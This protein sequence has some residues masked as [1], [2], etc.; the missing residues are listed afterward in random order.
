MNGSGDASMDRRGFLKGATFAGIGVA[1]AGAGLVGCAPNGESDKVA[2]DGSAT[3]SSIRA[4]NPDSI[5]SAPEIDESD[6]IETITCDVAVVGAGIS[7]VA[8]AR[9]AAEAGARVIV[10]EKN[11]DIE[12]HGFGCGVINSTFARSLGAEVDPLDVM[13]EYERRSYTRVNMPLVRLWAQHSGEVFDWYSALADQEILDSMT[14]NYHPLYPEHKPEQDLTQTFLGCIDFKEDPSNPIG[15]ATWKKLGDLNRER[16]EQ[17][18]AEFR[19]SV[20]GQ[21]LITDG[22][23]AV[24]GI[25]GMDADGNYLKV[26]TSKGVILTTGGFCQFGAG[27]ELMGKVY[28]P[29]LYK[30]YLEIVGKEPE[31]QPMFTVNP[32]T[33]QGS[34][35][36]GQLMAV[37]AGAVMD[38]WADSCMGSCE[39]G[40]G[41]TVA[42]TVNQLG[43]RFHNEDIGIWEKH[44]QVL[45]QPEQICYDIIDVN[46]RD[47]LPYQAIGHRNFDYHEHQ[48]AV[49]YDGFTY[50]DAF[51]EA[52][53]SSVGNPEGV[54]PTL[55]PHAGAVFGA[56]TLD[57][58]A[59][60]IGV[61]VDT[62][63]ETVAR[64]NEIVAQKRDEDF[65]CDPQK[66][67]PL[68]TPPFFAC[69]ATASPAF[70]AYAGLTADDQ[71]R[72]MS[73]EGQ[74]IKGLWAAG[75]C[76]GGKFAPSYF[77]PVP[78]M[79]HGNGIT[80]GYYAG[81]Y[82]AQD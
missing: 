39:S 65:G 58:L 20:A 66:L 25:I 26:E 76:C 41:G 80:H 50:V 69:S 30:N 77:T 9:S 1:M 75:N 62:F 17:A 79:N 21:R 36:D 19:F 35:G 38:P 18:G 2:S 28:T 14:L 72:V 52:F 67:F 45:R 48:V 43:K 44:N 11:Q 13:R 54:V 73:K 59:D 40:I 37:W 47:R 60:I 51:H 3:D 64:Y 68:D 23:G 78:A 4:G 42:L 15:S 49:G 10:L 57:E 24:T 34:T 31:W 61:P 53:L 32:G 27:S 82:A 71:L 12:I 74:P 5:G 46:W 70:G 56:E 63:K 16:A 55:D 29:S 8:A 22:S 81:L 6:I 33:I 7:G